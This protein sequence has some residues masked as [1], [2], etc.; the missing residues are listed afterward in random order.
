MPKKMLPLLLLLALLLGGCVRRETG[1]EPTPELTPAPTF[2]PYASLVLVPDGTGKEVWVV[3]RRELPLNTLEP[4]DFVPDGNYID[5][6]GSDVCAMRGIDVSEHQQDIDWEAVAADGVEFAMIR[7]GF[8][9]YNYGSFEED[10]FFHQNM[11]GAAAAG[12]K[13]GVYFFSQAISYEDAQAE[14]RFVLEEI[15]PYRDSITLPVCFDW[16]R[17]TWQS[18]RTD[19]VDA[20][21]LSK[22]ALGFAETVREAGYTPMV[23]F[24]RDMGY[25]VYDL[26]QLKDIDFWAGAAGTT[27]DFYYRHTIWQYSYTGRV[28]G[29]ST[30]CDLDLYF[31]YPEDETPSAE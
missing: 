1:P 4:G 11:Q 8:R 2:D 13:I 19:N 17:I 7:V 3:N 15:E 21:T 22:C 25:N 27:P 6:T 29:I 14:A 30:D 23:Y 5:Y 12:I 10:K 18:A 31:I 24:F 20:V 26:S 28:A 16:E 9:G